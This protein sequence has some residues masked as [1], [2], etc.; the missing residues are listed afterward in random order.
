MLGVP[1]VMFAQRYSLFQMPAMSNTVSFVFGTT[2][3]VYSRRRNVPMRFAVE[4]VVRRFSTLPTEPSRSVVH[5]ESS[6]ESNL[7]V[8][9]ARTLMRR[10][11]CPPAPASVQD[12]EVML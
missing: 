1:P 8:L 6:D 7:V 11:C 2:V 12:R 5:V 3:T 9:T 4:K 10:L